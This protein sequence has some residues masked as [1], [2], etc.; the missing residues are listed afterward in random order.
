V[1]GGLLF[2][3]GMAVLGYCPGT[4]MA[5][6]GEGRK[7]AA[8]G[9]LGMLG[10]ALAFVGAY[11]KIKPVIETGRV[12]TRTLPEL[13][14]TSPWLWIAAMAGTV[15]AASHFLEGGYRTSEYL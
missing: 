13:T 11:P 6:V 1:L 2:G 12:G 15:A 5:A 14:G 10:G 8:A 3:T 4:S 7:D 9:V